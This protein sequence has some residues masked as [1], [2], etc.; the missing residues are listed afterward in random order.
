MI[1]NK[2]PKIDNWLDKFL[3]IIKKSNKNDIIDLRC[4]FGN[5]T[6]YLAN[7][8]FSVLS[9]DYLKAALERLKYFIDNLKSIFLDMREPIP[10]DLNSIKI[11]ISDLSIHYH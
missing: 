3:P 8:G 4:G 11:I 7:K 9:C 10:F 5:D 2:A 1:G 6:L